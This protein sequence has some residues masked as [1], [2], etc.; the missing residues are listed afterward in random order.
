MGVFRRSDN[1]DAWRYCTVYSPKGVA[2]EIS[3]HSWWPN[4]EGESVGLL[5]ARLKRDMRVNPCVVV[6]RDDNVWIFARDTRSKL[7]ADAYSAI[8]LQGI[9]VRGTV[10]ITH[11]CSVPVDWVA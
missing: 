2:D 7:V 3:K 9:R 10:T 8:T 5:V 11:L 6:V 1:P 4:G